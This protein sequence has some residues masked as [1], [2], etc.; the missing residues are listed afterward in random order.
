M[1]KLFTLI[2]LLVVIAI[3]AILAAMLLPA[4]QKAKQKAEQ[5]TCSGNFKQ[6]GSTAALY[7]SDNKGI[8]PGSTPH[9]SGNPKEGY[10]DIE[11]L[12]ISQLGATLI[13]LANNGTTNNVLNPYGWNAA[14]GTS[15]TQI[16]W[17][18]INNKQMSI[19]QCPS[20][21]Y[22]DIAN[23]KA[24]ALASTVK[25]NLYELATA[26]AIWLTHGQKTVCTSIP[27]S[28]IDSAAGTIHYLENYGESHSEEFL[29]SLGSRESNRNGPFAAGG[30]G[31]AY[32]WGNSLKGWWVPQ[33]P[34]GPMHG[35]KGLPAGNALM[36]DGHVEFFTGTTELRKRKDGTLSPG[37][38]SIATA[39]TG[40]D[41]VL[42]MYS[43]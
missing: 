31:A 28:R 12:G 33:G 38:C 9:G 24:G 4:L 13:G 34:Y 17:T 16:G 36:H 5:S 1:K 23:S 35:N 37:P 39:D 11:A 8:K 7:G 42:F 27:N 20:Y 14:D 15:A 18:A 21:V 6:I 2:E 3:I 25:L 30:E 10:S 40:S 43:K 29:G 22:A 32:T 41:L 19:F 26:T